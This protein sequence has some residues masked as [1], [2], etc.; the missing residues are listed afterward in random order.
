MGGLLLACDRLYKI[1]TLYRDEYKFD[2][3]ELIILP[4]E[5]YV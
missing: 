2:R 1:E 3:I 5:G 4:I